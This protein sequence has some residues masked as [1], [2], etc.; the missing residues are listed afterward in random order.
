MYQSD[1]GGD[2]MGTE[3]TK[4]EK[5]LIEFVEVEHM[6]YRLEKMRSERYPDIH[7]GE[8]EFKSREDEIGY[9]MMCAMIAC[10]TDRKWELFSKIRKVGPF[11]KE[12]FHMDHYFRVVETERYGYV[13][14]NINNA[15]EYKE[16]NTWGPMPY[17]SFDRMVNEFVDD[18][19]IS[20][21]AFENALAD[22]EV[23]VKRMVENNNKKGGL[24]RVK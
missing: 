23:H 24:R 8:E 1:N 13:P 21:M 2:V 19:I 18:G 6:I 3:M 15:K 7:T 14:V 22:L 11:R 12:L 9:D 10:Y 5:Y 20:R 16:E 4:E 17:Q